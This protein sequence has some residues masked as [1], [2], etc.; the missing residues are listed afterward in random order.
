M[1]ETAVFCPTM[2]E[3]HAE[4][5]APAGGGALSRT[6]AQSQSALDARSDAPAVCCTYAGTARLPQLTAS[7]NQKVFILRAA[8]AELM[9]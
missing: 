3:F 1:T 5:N 8:S 6:S 7:K 2:P 9:Q 4:K